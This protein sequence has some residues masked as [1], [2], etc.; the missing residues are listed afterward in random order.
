MRQETTSVFSVR[1]NSY[2]LLLYRFFLAM[3]TFSICRIAFYF[4]NI[5]LYPDMTFP[6]FMRIMYGGLRFD[7]SAL[8]YVNSLFILINILPFR[9][10]YNITL[11]KVL[12]VLFV[13]TNAIVLFINIADFPYYRVTLRRTTFSF[14]TEF[15]ND[16][17]LGAIM[18]QGLVTYWYLF[19]L[20]IALVALLVFCY[21]PKF[22]RIRLKPLYFYITRIILMAVTVFFVITGMRSGFGRGTRPIT[23]SYAADYITKPLESGI[24]LNTPFSMIRTIQ[25]PSLQP[26]DYFSE[27][28]LG[29]IYTPLHVPPADISFK[30]RNVVIIIL[31]S[32]SRQ[33]I[34]ALNPDNPEVIG[35]TPFLDS[36]IQ[37]SRAYSYAYANGT[38]SIDAMPSVLASIPS[39]QNPF[40]LTPYSLNH[41]QGIGTLLHEKGYHTSFFH[42]AHNG[43]MGFSAMANLFGFEHYFGRDEYNDEKDFDGYW[44]IWDEPFMQFF[45]KEMNGF[46]QPFLSAIFTVSSH[47]PFK[48]PKQYEGVFPK[49]KNEVQECIGY[50]DHA[51][52]RFFETAGKMPWFENTLFVITADHGVWLELYPEYA[53]HMNSFGVPIIFYDPINPSDSG[54]HS[55]IAQQ[56]DI[57]PTVLD[58]LNYDKPYIAFGRSLKDSTSIPFSVNYHADAFQYASD[59][60]FLRFENGKTVDLYN[61]RKDK[62]MENNLVGKDSVDQ[63]PLENRLKA[64][65]Q[66][67]NNRMIKDELVP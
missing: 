67:Y 20:W 25:K 44:G 13:V 22:G 30:N 11:Q 36:L 51:L 53:N 49:G 8:L 32:F 64:F 27:T 14:F 29:K 26:L 34:A 19:V 10:I 31:E 4:F 43:S 58:Y 46:P 23:M 59:S 57:M 24:V 2:I 41:I 42:G 16:S 9:F 55:E 65:L 35:Y 45:A 63:S 3:L 1:N 21:G 28:E 66:Q 5:E 50:T 18:G 7:L 60:L 33:H 61:W 38:K 48:V 62:L 54:I 6:R 37:H 52:K 12:K 47:H 39:L 56:L 40:V 17:N 15:G